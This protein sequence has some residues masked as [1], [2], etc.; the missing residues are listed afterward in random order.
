MKLACN[1][2]SYDRMLAAGELTQLEWIDLCAQ[3]LLVDGVEFAAAHFPRTDDEY[4]AQL[5][6]LCTDRG[7]TIAGFHHDVAV[8][9]ADV[10]R[11][12][13]AIMRSLH[14]AALLGA[15]VVR[16]AC[17]AAV[18]PS[19]VAWREL[20]HGFK[21]IC[22]RAKA[23]NVTLALQPSAHSMVASPADAKRAIKE[24][25]SAWLRLALSGPLLA[26]EAAQIWLPLLADCVIVSAAMRELD[27]YGADTATDYLS[28]VGTLWQQRYRGF[29]TLEYSGSEAEATA[30]PRAA[31]WLQAISAKD[32]LRVVGST[33]V[34]SS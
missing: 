9:A 12:V 11:H 17:G 14:H 1:S 5:K 23:D 25:D 31:S 29:L 21:A 34:E 7:L 27:P 19:G 15:P 2:H 6:K 13:E 10:D 26:G 28:A 22:I 3:E 20:I 18:E 33:P 16:F 8:E 24:C 4:L 32:A 30:V